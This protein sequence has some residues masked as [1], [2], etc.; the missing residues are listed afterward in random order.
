MIKC[1]LNLTLTLL[2]I[3]LQYSYSQTTLYLSSSGGLYTTEKWIEITTLPNSAGLQIWG[4]GN[5]NYGNSPGLVTDV[6]FVVNCGTTY[7]INAYDKYDDS[8]DGTTYEIWTGPGKT[9]L[10]IANNGGLSPNDN[11]DDD[12]SPAFGDTQA[13]EL[14]VSE[15]FTTPCPCNAPTVVFSTNEDCINAQFFVDVQ[16]ANTGDA[17]AVDLTD[18]TTNYFSNVGPGN[19]QVGPFAYNSP[20]IIEADGTAY[21]GCS[22]SSISLNE[23]CQCTNVPSAVTATSN[24]NCSSASYDIQVTVSNYGDGISA[25][26]LIDGINVQPNALLGQNYLFAGYATGSHNVQIVASGPGFVDCSQSYLVNASCNGTDSWSL[27]APDITNNCSSGDL[28]IASIDGPTDFGPFCWAGGVAGFGLNYL[29]PCNAGF[30][31]TTDFTDIWYQVDLPDGAD[32]M[33]LELTGLNNNEFVAYT[34]HTNGP[35][36]SSDDFMV[37]ATANQECSFFSQAVTSHTINGLAA[38]STAP[39]YIRVLAANPNPNLGCGLY[40]HPTFSICATA[41]QANDACNDALDITINNGG[42]LRNGNLADANDEGINCL[43]AVNG[44]DLWYKVSNILSSDPSYNGPYKVQFKANGQTGERM[45]VQLIDGCYNCGTITVLAT[46]TLEFFSPDS[47]DFGGFQLSGGI[48]DYRIRVVELGTTTSFVAEAQ[49]NVVNDVCDYFNAPVTA[50]SLW[51]GSNPIARNVA[52]NFATE[53]DLFYN[54]SSIAAVPSY[55]GSVDFSI[56]GLGSNESLLLEVYERNPLYSTDCNNLTLVGTSLSIVTDGVYTYDCLNQYEGD[57]LVRVVDQGT[58]PATVSLSATPS[59]AAPINDA[60]TAIWDGNNITFEG[61]AFNITGTVAAGD[62]SSARHCAPFNSLC[63]G[64]DLTAEK[65]LWYVFEMPNSNCPNISASSTINDID[66]F[67]D[68]SDAS[69]DAYFYVYEDCDASTLIDCS[70]KMDGAGQTY[71]IRN[72]QA[73]QT[74]LLR[75][76]PY[77]LNS[78]NNFSFNVSGTLGPV[79]PCN[80]R[81]ENASSLGSLLSS[82]FDRTTCLN[83][84]F[85]AQ[86]ATSSST[87]SSGTDVWLSF[88]APNPANGQVYQQAES[89]LTIYLQSLSGSGNPYPLNLRVYDEVGFNNSVGVPLGSTS[90]GSGSSAT[91]NSNGDGWLSLGHLTP[92]EIYYI[93]IAHNQA[94]GTAV[95]YN[96]CLYETAPQNPCIQTSISVEQGIECNDDC[97]KYFKIELPE[98]SPSSFFRFEAIGNNGAEVN[99]RMFYQP[100]ESLGTSTGNITDVDQ[101]FG[102]QSLLPKVGLGP[103]PDPGT[104]NAGTGNYS[105]FN[106][107][108]ASPGTANLYYLEVYDE[109]NLLG[110]GGLDICQININGPFSTLALAQTNG[111]PDIN[112]VNTLPLELLS[113]EGRTESNFNEISWVTAREMTAST[114]GL[115]RSEDGI[116]FETI[117]QIVVEQNT[118]QVKH[119]R[120]EDINYTPLSYYR[121]LHLDQSEASSFS[122]II[123]L[124]RTNAGYWSSRPNPFRDYLELSS[125][126]E[127]PKQIVLRNVLGATVL[128]FESQHRTEQIST[129]SLIPGTYSLSI[130]MESTT[131]TR[132]IIKE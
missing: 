24:L 118:D 77:A 5:G 64:L 119:Y 124:E 70:G 87:P 34:L 18:G 99:M 51:N 14:E 16:L 66:I 41:P 79:R 82:G 50:F 49:L 47:T 65:D 74:Y 56:T 4:Q 103:L 17:T 29:R 130:Y 28:S 36:A 52:M 105:I 101:A 40:T 113:F 78:S 109:N 25:A 86:G 76:K 6:P 59:A 38:Y 75:I 15:G 42:S 53:D 20:V 97:S 123:A 12:A 39:I 46:D 89:Y 108:G 127:G 120:F 30:D 43:A 112:C 45:I 22:S 1:R 90:V 61:N 110:C 26:I 32:Q 98:G 73:G 116:N 117:H 62:F 27:S 60:C 94:T 83:G 37:N 114:Y 68:A 88:M 48:S 57:Y 132:K 72:L 121:L 35:L 100:N 126:P 93:R 84:P 69:K 80:D 85:S 115:Q 128:S 44:K 104:C 63:N 106:L 31:N 21:S 54:F 10:L 71:S 122:K 81:P 92:G 95:L 91:T 19:Y 23:T 67:Y 131:I 33:T 13:D 107:I 55:S 8:W 129:V 58:N 9:G 3:S 96:L 102:V 111:T 2:I 125:M 11:N 7:Y